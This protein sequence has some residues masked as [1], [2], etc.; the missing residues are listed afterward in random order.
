MRKVKEAKL[1]AKGQITVPKEVRKILGVDNGDTVAFYFED[2]AVKLTSI[3][4]LKVQPKNKTKQGE[5]K[6]ER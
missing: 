2:N 4:N 6:K 3:N 5:I 1:S